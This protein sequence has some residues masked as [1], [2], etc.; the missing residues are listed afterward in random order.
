MS[1]YSSLGV[2]TVK[3]DWQFERLQH[4]LENKF[5]ERIRTM[6][7][8]KPDLPHYLNSTNNLVEEVSGETTGV[9]PFPPTQALR[10][11]NTL[12]DL[13]AVDEMLARHTEIYQ[14]ALNSIVRTSLWQYQK[15]NAGRLVSYT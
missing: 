13:A 6:A 7:T 8:I 9:N 4:E 1:P 15:R 10:A 2:S 5:I 14:A 11:S 12:K 3:L